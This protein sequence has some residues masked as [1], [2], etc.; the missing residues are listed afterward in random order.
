MKYP[1]IRFIIKYS[2]VIINQDFKRYCSQ[3]FHN[4]EMNIHLTVKLINE[5]YESYEDNINEMIDL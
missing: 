3:R 1:H 5:Y 2:K 4:I